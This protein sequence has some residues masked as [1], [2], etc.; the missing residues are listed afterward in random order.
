M[1]RGFLSAML[2]A[3]LA[4]AATASAHAAP[5]TRAAITLSGRLDYVTAPGTPHYEVAGY[6]LLYAD[7]TTL[8]SMAGQD[9]VVV[10][11]R[12]SGPTI[13]M[14]P[15]LEVH[16]VQLKEAA[17]D[18]VTL[19]VMPNPAPSEP[20]Q[21]PA[22]VRGVLPAVPAPAPLSAPIMTRPLKLPPALAQVTLFSRAG[23][24][25]FGRPAIMIRN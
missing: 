4:L 16:S 14:R 13:Y 18:P 25:V 8:E 7:D 11:V 1:I 6:V 19:P 22:P 20:A 3:V 24:A 12:F 23:Y 10:G 21:P 9:V 2:A 5:T 15:T 17:G